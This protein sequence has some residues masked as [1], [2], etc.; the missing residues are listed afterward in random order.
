MQTTVAKKVLVIEDDQALSTA[1]LTGLTKAG[2]KPMAAFNGKS[3]LEIAL[4][5]VPDVIILDLNMPEMDGKSALK[6][7]KSQP[8]TKDIPVIVATNTA[9]TDSIYECIAA[10]AKDYILKS[11]TSIA[12]IIQQINKAVGDLR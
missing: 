6:I 2:F 1:L 7:L 8:S 5:E 3:G 12:D 9:G 10:G 11:D 4:R